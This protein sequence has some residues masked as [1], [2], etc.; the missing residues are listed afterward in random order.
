MNILCVFV[1]FCGSDSEF[2]CSFFPCFFKKKRF[3]LDWLRISD[4]CVTCIDF[5][6]ILII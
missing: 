2:L 5:S 6:G 3:L 1:M 4:L